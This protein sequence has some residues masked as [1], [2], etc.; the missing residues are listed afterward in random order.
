MLLSKRVANRLSA[1]EFAWQAF[2]QEDMLNQWGRFA[3]SDKF[4][5]LP[6][7]MS[8][9]RLPKFFTKQDDFWRV[10]FIAAHHRAYHVAI[11]GE[12]LPIKYDYKYLTPECARGEDGIMVAYALKPS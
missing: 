11:R 3:Y 6:L 12:V 8:A 9:R 10:A 2:S 5:K 4:W 7:R 1:E